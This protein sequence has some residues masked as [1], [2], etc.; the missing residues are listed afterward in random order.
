[1]KKCFQNLETCSFS[2][3]EEKV[4]KAFILMPFDVAFDEIYRVGIKSGLGEIGWECDRSD[5]RWDTPNVVYTICKSIQE[6]S[7]EKEYPDVDDLLKQVIA[8]KKGFIIYT[9]EKIDRSM[10]IQN[11]PSLC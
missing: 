10:S 3:I 9:E 11:E 8:K 5:E 1:M 6:A 7:K 2:P 4:N